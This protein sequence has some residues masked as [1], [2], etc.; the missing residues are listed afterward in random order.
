MLFFKSTKKFDREYPNFDSEISC[1]ENNNE[2]FG[3]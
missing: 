1:K 2:K 3:L